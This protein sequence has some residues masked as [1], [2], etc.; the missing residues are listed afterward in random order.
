MDKRRGA[1]S[2]PH[3]AFLGEHERARLRDV[4]PRKNAVQQRSRETVAAILE[5]AAQVFETKG[6]AAATTDEIARRAGVSIGT[7]YQYFPNKDAIAVVWMERHGQDGV[8]AVVPVLQRLK[9]DPPPLADGI[10]LLVRAYLAPHL[11]RPALHRAIADEATVP[12][13]IRVR[14]RRLGLALAPLLEAYFRHELGE[15]PELPR[16]AH[17]VTVSI[18]SLVHAFTADAADARSADRIAEEICRMLIATLPPGKTSG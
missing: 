15:H 8:D 4:S 2:P 13:A 10:A 11:E 1:T 6:F 5:G 17:A 12:P 7:L 16:A 3:L 18:E 14:R 9:D